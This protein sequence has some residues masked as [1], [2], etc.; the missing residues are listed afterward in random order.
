MGQHGAGQ[1]ED[2][3]GQHISCAEVLQVRNHYLDAFAYRF[4]RR[5]DL[6]GLVARLIVDVARCL[7]ARNRS[8]ERMLRQV[9]SQEAESLVKIVEFFE[10]KY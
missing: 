2:D 9:T 7:P 4:N 3:A 10:C 1:L 6:R 8:P 5:F